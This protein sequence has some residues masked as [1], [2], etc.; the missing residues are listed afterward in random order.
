MPDSVCMFIYYKLEQQKQTVTIA[1]GI[2]PTA[3][4]SYVTY[5]ISN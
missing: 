3:N 1:A 5:Y 4:V 2:Q